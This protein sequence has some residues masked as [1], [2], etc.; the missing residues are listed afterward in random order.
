MYSDNGG[1]P[2]NRLAQTGVVTLDGAAAGDGVALEPVS[3]GCGVESTPYWL[4][5][6]STANGFLLQTI[7]KT[8]TGW[9]SMFELP[10]VIGGWLDGDMPDPWPPSQTPP[11]HIATP[12]IYPWV[13]PN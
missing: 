7:S 2:G 11:T 10:D 3:V 12:I 9:T 4:C 6:A 13:V 8:D 5:I 1:Y